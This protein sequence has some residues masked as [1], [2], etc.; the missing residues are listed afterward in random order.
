MLKNLTTLDEINVFFSELEKKPRWDS[1]RAQLYGMAYTQQEVQEKE[2]EI[3]S[4]ISSK[5][6]KVLDCKIINEDFAIISANN[7]SELVYLPVVNGTYIKEACLSFDEALILC[8]CKKYGQER[9]APPMIF[10]MLRM[11]QQLKS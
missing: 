7:G 11:D 9:C 1:I 4:L 5:H 8:L 2:R 3:C 6:F 10:N